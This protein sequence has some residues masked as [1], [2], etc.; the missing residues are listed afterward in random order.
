MIIDIIIVICSLLMV[1]QFYSSY[2]S[3]RSL[4][5]QQN[6]I[7]VDWINRSPYINGINRNARNDPSTTKRLG[8][9]AAVITDVSIGVSLLNFMLY[10][11]GRI[12]MLMLCGTLLMSLLR[13][14]ILITPPEGTIAPPFRSLFLPS[15][16][17]NYNYLLSPMIFYALVFALNTR[18]IFLGSIF[19]LYQLWYIL[20]MKQIYLFELWMTLIFYVALNSLFY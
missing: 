6:S 15:D 9:V 13:S 14:S 18:H 7:V 4:A 2:G 11:D 8:R 19:L 3:I 10:E 20:I 17:K 1:H 5:G 16:G 12:F